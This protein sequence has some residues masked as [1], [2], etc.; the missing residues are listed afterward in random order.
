[1]SPDTELLL[2]EFRLLREEVTE[3][4][5]RISALETDNHA[6]MGNGQPGRLTKVEDA[7]Q[8]LRIEVTKRIWWVV[9]AAAGVSSVVTGIA[10]LIFR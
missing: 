9:G 7:I 1:M 6:V 3:A 5:Q 2:N 8:S 10:W 4:L